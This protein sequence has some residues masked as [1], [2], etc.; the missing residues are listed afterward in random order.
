[1]VKEKKDGKKAVIRKITDEQ[2]YILLWILE[3]PKEYRSGK[4]VD[5]SI[6]D[7]STMDNKPKKRW[8]YVTPEENELI[9]DFLGKRSG[10][11]SSEDFRKKLGWEKDTKCESI[12]FGS[13]IQYK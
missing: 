6:I 7:R 8:F 5:T 9:K 10:R 12:P 1:M 13:T 3:H 2:C 4:L 11:T